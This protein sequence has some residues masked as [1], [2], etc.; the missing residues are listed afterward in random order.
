LT[1][2]LKAGMLDFCQHLRSSRNGKLVS[3][4]WR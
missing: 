4:A 3:Q 2:N 1:P